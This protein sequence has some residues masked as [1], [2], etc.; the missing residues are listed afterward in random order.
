MDKTVQMRS[1]EINESVVR[2][3]HGKKPEFRLPIGTSAL[4]DRPVRFQ[5]SR[6]DVTEGVVGLPFS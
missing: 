1:Y 5:S 2:D 6:S 3:L 4:L